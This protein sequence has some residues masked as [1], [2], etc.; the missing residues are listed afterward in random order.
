MGMSRRLGASLPTPQSERLAHELVSHQTSAMECS[1]TG[2]PAIAGP[3]SAH[4]SCHLKHLHSHCY[5][6]CK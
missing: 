5:T 6:K 1:R 4:G 2:L 3:L